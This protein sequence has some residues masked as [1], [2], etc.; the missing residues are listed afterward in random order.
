MSGSGEVRGHRRAH[1]AEPDETHARLIGRV[2][3]RA[4]VHHVVAF[5]LPIRTDKGAA[6][7]RDNLFREIA[8]IDPKDTIRPSARIAN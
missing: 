6:S 1:A 4:R 5:A 3:V 2:A 7:P 8:A